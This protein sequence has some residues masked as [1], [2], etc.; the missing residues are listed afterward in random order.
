MPAIDP[1]VKSMFSFDLNGRIDGTNDW[2]EHPLPVVHVAFSTDPREPVVRFG[3]SIEDPER[4]AARIGEI[5][6][7]SPA[8]DDHESL[9]RWC[10]DLAEA[11]RPLGDFDING[12]P[13]YAAD[14]VRAA[15]PDGTTLITPDNMSLLER[16]HAD[17]LADVAHQRP[18][19]WRYSARTPSRSAQASAN[20]RRRAVPV[21]VTRRG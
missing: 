19:G 18:M 10:D 16:H 17:W 20:H 9:L 8:P 15:P 14:R 21:R 2:V 5:A 13:S 3:Q 4:W 1:H 11:L 7:A 12:G 6:A